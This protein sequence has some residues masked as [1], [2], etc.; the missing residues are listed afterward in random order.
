MT[1]KVS[2][3]ILIGPSWITCQSGTNHVTRRMDYADWPEVGQVTTFLNN[4]VCLSSPA[5]TTCLCQTV[6]YAL[7]SPTSGSS[8]ALSSLPVYLEIPQGPVQIQ[9][10]RGGFLG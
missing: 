4:Q 3:L 6:G 9:R 8:P 7:Y 5:Q 2:W 10:L 1:T